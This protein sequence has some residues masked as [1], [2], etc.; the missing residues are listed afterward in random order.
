MN[1]IIINSNTEKIYET[2]EGILTQVS[3]RQL[4]ADLFYDIK[5]ILSELF[6]NAFIHGNK[7]DPSKKITV[8]YSIEEKKF[9]L[10][11]ADEGGGFDYK[12]MRD[13]ADGENIIKMSGRG[14]FLVK[15]LSDGV[16]FNETG[17]E[18]TIEKNLDWL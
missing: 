12:N 11:I 18:I 15:H 5:L 2:I 13:P 3:A 8:R 4:P 1:L 6:V 16:N 9:I 14:L 7:Q 10:T 17:N